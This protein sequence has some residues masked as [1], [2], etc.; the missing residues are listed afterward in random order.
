VNVISKRELTRLIGKHPQAAE[1]LRVWFKIARAAQ[2]R[3]LADVRV[4]FPSADLVGHVLIFD[5]LHNG[6]RL[7]T[8]ASWRSQRLYVKALLTHKQYDREEWKKWV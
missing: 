4:N 5:I 3:S 7:I 8:V 6:L 1:E 2:W